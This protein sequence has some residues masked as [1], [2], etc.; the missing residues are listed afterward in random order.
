MERLPSTI[1]LIRRGGTAMALASLVCDRAMG[2]RNSSRISPGCGFRRSS[3]VVDDFDLVRIVV[4]PNKTDPPL[5]VDADLLP[6]SL[7]FQ[8]LQS[9][10]WRHARIVETG[11]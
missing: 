7:P 4:F 3:V 5:A 10:S 8:R 1:S 6:M 2:V 11:D 9:I